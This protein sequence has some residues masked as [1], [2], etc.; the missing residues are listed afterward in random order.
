MGDHTRTLTQHFI[1][2]TREVG[3]DLQRYARPGPLDHRCDFRTNWLTLSLTE[4]VCLGPSCRVPNAAQPFSG[5]RILRLAS[6]PPA[7]AGEL[8]QDC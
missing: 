1:L 7:E 6:T 8:A 5:Q 2:M 4:D 3:A